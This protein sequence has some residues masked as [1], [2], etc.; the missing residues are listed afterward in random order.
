M[1]VALALILALKGLNHS[2]RV[3]SSVSTAV[4]E[5]KATFRTA[6]L[7]FYVFVLSSCLS[8]CLSV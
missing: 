7:L 4:F 1:T 6:V 5:W 2:R 3:N 8:V